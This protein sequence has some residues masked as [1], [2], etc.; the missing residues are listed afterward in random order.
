MRK[1]IFSSLKNEGPFILEWVSYHLSIGF[2]TVVIASNECTDG[3]HEL[4]QALDVR[5]VILH[6]P[7]P[8]D[9][10]SDVPP[11]MRA[12]AFARHHNAF[13]EGDYV[14]WLDM[15][16]FLVPPSN[17]PTVDAMIAD[18]Q[19]RG[20]DALLLNWR[21]MGDSGHR[22]LPNGFVLDEFVRCARNVSPLNREVKTLFAYSDRV[23]G[24]H[25]HQPLWKPEYFNEI[26][27]IDGAGQ[28]LPDHYLS[29]RS[30]LGA[31]RSGVTPRRGN[32]RLGRINHYCVRTRDLFALKQTRGLGF[33]GSQSGEFLDRY[34]M[35]FFEQ[36]NQNSRQ[37]L[38]ILRFKPGL[39]VIYSAL[40]TDPKIATL[41]AAAVEKTLEKLAPR[42]ELTD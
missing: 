26:L 35:E 28:R 6:L 22:G 29:R 7:V 15:D 21:V 16:E 38:D 36:Q 10:A 8:A 2:D 27:L 30:K 17:S 20:A 33:F 5:G 40:L 32:S 19:A 12:E 41:H 4:L 23:K 24:L 18:M 42:L 9:A 34:S 37:N 31:P 3:S 39:L 11:Q 14:L 25:V 1:V 13:K